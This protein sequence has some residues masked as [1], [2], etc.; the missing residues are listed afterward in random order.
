M[1]AQKSLVNINNIKTNNVNDQEANQIKTAIKE[2]ADAPIYIDDTP[3]ISFKELKEN[4]FKL[5]EEKGIG[6]IL[7]HYLQ[8]ITGS[9]D[10]NICAS[11]K[12]LARDLD[13][14]VVVTSQLSRK[15]EER[16][17]K[18]ENPRPILSDINTNILGESDVLVF[19]YRDDYYNVDTENKDIT[20]LIIARN[21]LGD[22]GTVKLAYNKECLKYD[23]LEGN[24]KE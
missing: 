21:K 1:I 8:L 9:K 2:L 11:L 15:P 13:I 3:A 6:L 22:T 17:E 24:I 12:K 20:E 18:G 19:L 14:P 7:V 5:K 23:N 16:F 4:S 10:E